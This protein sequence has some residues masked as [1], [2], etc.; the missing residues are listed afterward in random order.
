MSMIWKIRM[1]FII[2]EFQNLI[3]KFIASFHPLPLQFIIPSMYLWYLLS[4][5]H[6]GVFHR[7]ILIQLS[8]TSGSFLNSLSKFMKNFLRNTDVNQT[9]TCFS[10]EETG[11]NSTLAAGSLVAIIIVPFI[12]CLTFAGIVVM[13]FK[14]KHQMRMRASACFLWDITVLVM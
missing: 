12:F 6:T 7:H 8:Q 11:S 9:A 2:L 14:R 5:Y 1:C 13:W 4:V 3:A 10:T